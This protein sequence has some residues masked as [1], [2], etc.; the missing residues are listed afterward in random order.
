M[1]RERKSRWPNPA[2]NDIETVTRG[3]DG[4]AGNGRRS[5]RPIEPFA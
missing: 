3:G 2:G 1:L 4:M 5:R